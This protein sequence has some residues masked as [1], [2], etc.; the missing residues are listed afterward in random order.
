MNLL[1]SPIENE[2]CQLQTISLDLLN[3]LTR[4]ETQGR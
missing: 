1:Q 3:S 4:E 2:N